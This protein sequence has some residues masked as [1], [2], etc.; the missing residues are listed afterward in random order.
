VQRL[1]TSTDSFAT[2][3][4]TYNV[5]GQ[6]ATLA[7]SGSGSPGRTLTYCY[8]SCDT[9]SNDN[10]QITQ[11][12][13][14]TSGETISYLYDSLKRLTSATATVT[15]GGA[16]V[17]NQ[18]YGYDGFGNL[19]S[20]VLN[21]GANVIPSMNSAN[22][23]LAGSG[24]Y[25]LNGNLLGGPG[26]TLTYDEANR[27]ASA[28]P[29]MGQPEY[30]GYA[31][32]NK[33]I[34]RLLA[35]GLEEWTF[36]GAHGEKVGVYGLRDPYCCGYVDSGESYHFVPKRT[37]VWF[38]GQLISDNDRLGTNR[39]GGAEFRPYGDEIGTASANDRE[40]FGTYN[41]DSA[42]GMDYADQR[43][44]A[45]SYGRF[46]TADQY[47]ASAGPSDPGSWNRYAYV[48][49]D[50]VNYADPGGQK[51]V[52]CTGAGGGAGTAD[53]FAGNPCWGTGG[54][55]DPCMDMFGV[56]AVFCNGGYPPVGFFPPETKVPP[57]CE[58]GETAFVTNYL[59][60]KGAPQWLV[61]NAGA[62]VSAADAAGVDDRFL[63]ALA[64]VETTYG[65][66]ITA[67]W[68][69]YNA[70][71]DSRHCGILQGDCQTVNPYANGMQAINGVIANI[72]G[73]NYF[74]NQ[75]PLV[76]TTDI[77]QKGYCK[78]CS[79]G[80]PTGPW[81][82]TDASLNHFYIGYMGGGLLDDPTAVNFSRCPQ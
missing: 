29:S 11:M 47:R 46:N 60:S 67:T 9:P 18:A 8:T 34:Y 64:G 24:L 78:G 72:T 27:L 16:A 26:A 41:R 80:S 40:K 57:T 61:S 12:K 77:Y 6:L 19:T 73:K 69:P 51:A 3:A 45:S 63:V 14:S 70:W 17:W 37:N 31:P 76:T 59:K 36:Y 54:W 4:D 23:Q 21:S 22:N 50:P 25:D 30:Y 58:E 79:A 55:F 82:P 38:A 81:A 65:K 42:T 13:D 32:D 33:R 44:Y 52:I 48:G 71:S 28:T 5:N 35:S 20:S 43:Y 7:W 56:D 2:E 66:N 62:L 10:G 75:T 15:V 39:A 74:Q 68:G 1:V 53:G 49:G